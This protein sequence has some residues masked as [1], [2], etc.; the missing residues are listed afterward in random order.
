M[1]SGPCAAKAGG[2]H[3]SHQRVGTWRTRFLRD[4]LDGLSDEP[5]PGWPRTITDDQVEQVVVTT[6]ETK[7][8]DATH[9]S[10]RSLASQIGMSQTA[11]SR[12][13]R[14]FGSNPTRSTRSRSARIRCSWTKS[15]TWSVS[16]SIH[17]RKAV[18]LC[19]DEKS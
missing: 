2:D 14:A 17:P 7:P 6:L 19:V 4:R 13:W 10:T 5:R 16:T 8:A 18:V 1:S 11:V 9:W 12:I 15:A 3:T